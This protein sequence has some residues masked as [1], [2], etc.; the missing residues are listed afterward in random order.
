MPG[1]FMD[2]NLRFFGGMYRNPKQRQA[3]QGPLYQYTTGWIIPT[4]KDF[5]MTA[6][7]PEAT[8]IQVYR[9]KKDSAAP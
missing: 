7:T 4:E 5:A 6:E 9:I 8:E 3:R 1:N 2:K